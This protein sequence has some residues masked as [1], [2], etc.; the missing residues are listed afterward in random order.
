MRGLACLAMFQT[1]GYDSWL[2]PAARRSTLFMYSQLGGTLPA[3][4]FLF[5]AGISVALVTDKLRR[6]GEMPWTVASTTMRRGAEVLGLGLLFRLQ[7]FLFNWRW[8]PWT[9]LLRVDI[10]NTIGVSI[11]LMGA[12]C[13]VTATLQGKKLLPVVFSSSRIAAQAQAAAASASVGGTSARVS[14]KLGGARPLSAA[15]TIA[16]AAAVALGISLL[17]PGLWTTY[18]PRFLPWPLESYINGVHVFPAPKGW[19]F[20]IFP[21]AGFAFVGLA[22]GFLLLSDA[23]KRHEAAAFLSLG[24]GGTGLM[25]FSRWL[26]RQPAHFYA[27]YNYWT[28]SPEFFLFRVGLLLAILLAVYAWCRW[29]AGQLGWSPLVQLGQT[30]LLVYWVH[31]EFVYDRFMILPSHANDVR[32]ASLGLAFITVFMLVVSCL[33]T[34]WREMRRR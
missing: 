27:V 10:L 19:F 14:E 12:L 24:A 1:H 8:A 31:I 5:L 13:W 29:G 17:S 7:Q 16:A 28:T 32:R 25:L 30:S 22:T 33:R 6:Q 34:R 15:T 21:W 4:L 9:D 18:R 20:P 3:P 23:V 2:S 11:M 26:N